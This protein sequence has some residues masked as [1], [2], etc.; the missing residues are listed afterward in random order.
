MDDE[1]CECACHI[2]G[3]RMA[4]AENRRRKLRVF[5]DAPMDAEEWYASQEDTQYDRMKERYYDED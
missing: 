1:M 5:V 3:S 4:R 2:K